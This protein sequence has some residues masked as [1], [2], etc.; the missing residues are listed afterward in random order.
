VTAPV[1]L[2]PLL[3]ASVRSRERTGAGRDTVTFLPLSRPSRRAA[4]LDDAS[5]SRL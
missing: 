3:S 2:C 5:E 4:T 1:P